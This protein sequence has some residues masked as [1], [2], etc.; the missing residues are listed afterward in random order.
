MAKKI[1]SH[2]VSFY[3]LFVTSIRSVDQ[4]R[5]S[6]PKLLTSLSNRGRWGWSYRT[7]CGVIRQTLKISGHYMLSNGELSQNYSQTEV[8]NAHASERRVQQHEKSRVINKDSRIH[9]SIFYMTPT[10]RRSLPI[11]TYRFCFL[12]LLTSKLVWITMISERI[13]T[14]SFWPIVQCPPLSWAVSTYSFFLTYQKEEA[15]A[16]HFHVRK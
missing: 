13:V 9:Y 16:K 15:G 3:N 2:G 8:V 5:N 1:T 14:V 7:T 12:G 4:Q 11:P 10:I 6:P